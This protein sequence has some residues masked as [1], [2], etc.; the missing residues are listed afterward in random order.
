MVSRAWR[1]SYDLSIIHKKIAYK[2]SCLI[3]NFITRGP[4]TWRP[5]GLKSSGHDHCMDTK[6]YSIHWGGK[7][8]TIRIG[9][10]ARQAGGSC[11]VQ[12]G[13]TVV[14]C[15][16]TMGDVREDLNFFPLHVD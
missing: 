6:E 7:P 5:N 3:W 16:A 2:F 12:Y 1:G 8:L 13:D 14:L 4:K 10:L 9:K 15:T 11:T